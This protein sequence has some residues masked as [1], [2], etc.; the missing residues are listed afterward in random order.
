MPRC[1]IQ[2]SAGEAGG[3]WKYFKCPST[4]SWKNDFYIC[5]N[6]NDFDIYRHFH[7]A[8][9]ISIAS[10]IRNGKRFSNMQNGDLLFNFSVEIFLVSTGTGKK[11]IR[12][13]RN[14]NSR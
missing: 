7:F 4:K 1:E 3:R 10:V 14:G 11:R 12:K 6:D 8:E 9:N 2:R 13:F 5:R